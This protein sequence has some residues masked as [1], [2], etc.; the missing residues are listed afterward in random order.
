VTVPHRENRVVIF[1]STLFHETDR[2]EF[3]EG[4]ENRRIN[5]TLLFGK[6]LH[7]G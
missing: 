7:S 2:V 6:R 4:Y 3:R 5:V 1:N